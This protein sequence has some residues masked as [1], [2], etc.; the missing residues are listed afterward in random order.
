M[1]RGG[2]HVKRVQEKR[3]TYKNDKYEITR[4][5]FKKN[6]SMFTSFLKRV[7]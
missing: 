1:D 4:Y 6:K 2:K 7:S 5:M 3:N